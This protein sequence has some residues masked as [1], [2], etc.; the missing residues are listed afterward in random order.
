MAQMKCAEGK[1]GASMEKETTKIEKKVKVAHK[2]PQKATVT[3]LFNVTT[4]QV[5]KQYRNKKQTNYGYIVTPDKAKVD[6]T[7]WYSG[8]VEKLYV[9]TLYMKVS[10]ADPLV[11]VYSPEVYQAKQDY[12]NS[13]RYNS[14][15]SA[16]AMLKSAMT[17][18]KLLG[19]DTREIKKIKKERKVDAYTTI[20]APSS[21][22]IFKKNINQGSAIMPKDKLFEI[23]DLKHLWVEV[24]LFQEQSLQQHTLSDFR[25]NIKGIDKPF[26]AKK[27]LIYPVVNKNE[28]TS[29][30]RLSIENTHAQLRPG[31]YV[32]IDSYTDKKESLIIP[33]TAAI[34]KNGIW[35]AFLATEFKGEYEP[36]AIEIKPLDHTSYEV[37]KGLTIQDRIVNNALFMMDSDA[38][39][40]SIY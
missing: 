1:C 37:I 29:T 11:K 16:T 26:K 24:K 32:T 25:V 30:L 38:Q 8:F 7:A 36:I 9:D 20:Y 15:H 12:L 35:Y 2:S 21:G 13:L 40:N 19:V 28:A 22:W 18:L 5:Q 17:K 23:V 14:T 34:R 33:R 27:E 6:V 3:Q 4:V 31:M 39:I 10:K